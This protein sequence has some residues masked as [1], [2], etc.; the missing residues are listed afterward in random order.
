MFA[1]LALILTVTTAILVSPATASNQYYTNTNPCNGTPAYCC[2]RVLDAYKSNYVEQLNDYG[3]PISPDT[4]TIG[5]K[6]D[7]ITVS[8]SAPA[9]SSKCALSTVCCQN[10]Y[11]GKLF[12]HDENRACR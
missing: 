9:G 12:L 2:D 6:C 11:F 10:N 7:P 3:I 8:A 1:N 5:L 4:A